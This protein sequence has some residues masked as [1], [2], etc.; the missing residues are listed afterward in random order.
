MEKPSSP[1]PA[2]GQ[3]KEFF[4][5]CCARAHQLLELKAPR[6]E[7]LGCLVSAA[8]SIGGPG[9]VSSILVVDDEGLL[10]NGAS[11]NLPDD[12]LRAI[13]RL[14][15]HPRVGTCAAAA[16]TGAIVITPDFNADDKWAELRHL[17]RSLGFFGAWSMPIKASNGR[18]L[19]TFGTYF[20]ERREPTATEVH[21]MG[22]LVAIAAR[23]LAGG[24]E[25]T[26]P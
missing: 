15:P 4:D 22:I 17:P 5:Q 14:K 3:I 1:S 2:P 10:R 19:G 7:T 20:R 25:R 9:T 6:H 23:V 13:D 24:A 21:H 26:E 16:A 18:V 12:Y 11:P 8:E